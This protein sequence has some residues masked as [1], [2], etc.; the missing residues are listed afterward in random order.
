MDALDLVCAARLHRMCFHA[1]DLF[2]NQDV[3]PGSCA[4]RKALP[5]SGGLPT[6]CRVDTVLLQSTEYDLLHKGLGS[7]FIT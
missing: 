2:I 6:R 5:G 1:T 7:G 4:R 3:F